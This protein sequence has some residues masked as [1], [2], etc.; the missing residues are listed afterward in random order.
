MKSSLV[1][2]LGPVIVAGISLVAPVFSAVLVDYVPVGNA[3]NSADPATGGVYGAVA[4][5][6]NISKNETTIGQYAEFLNTVAKSDPYGLYSTNMA[7]RP[8]V[9]GINRSGSD[10]SYTYSVVAGTA[11]MPISY[12]NWFDAARFCNWLHNGQG[13]GSTETGAYTLNGAL[14]GIIAKN[15]DATVWIPTENEWYKA[16]YYDPTKNGVGGYWSQATQ[17]DT[18]NGNTVGTAD[19]ANYFDGDYVGSGNGTTPTTIALTEVGA[20]GLNSQSAY[21]T[22]DQGGNLFEL[23]DAVITGTTRGGRGGSWI[24]SGSAEQGAGY[25]IEIEP[26]FQ[27]YSIGFRVASVPE[28]G[29]LALAMLAGAGLLTRRRRS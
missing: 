22:N 3:G 26:T 1:S 21:G 28:P 8:Y 19:S 11:N 6:Y 20:Y 14:S 5:N 24:N 9:A 7:T 23:N 17:S 15:S 16:A 2:P 12:V 18:L 29:S 25:R 27:S 13:S 10:G 4:Y